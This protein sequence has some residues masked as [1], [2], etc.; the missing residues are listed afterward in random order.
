MVKISKYDDS[1]RFHTENNMNYTS[2]NIKKGKNFNTDYDEIDSLRGSQ[3]IETRA[4]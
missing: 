3:K 4:Y 1:T 2:F